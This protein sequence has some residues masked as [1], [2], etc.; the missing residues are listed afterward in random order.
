MVPPLIILLVYGVFN[1]YTRIKRPVI[2]FAG[3][4]VF[5]AWHGVYLWKYIAE[6]APWP[7]LI[8][9]ESRD[10]Y[11]S[12][13]LPEY[14]TFRFINRETTANARIYL[15]FVGRRAYYCQRNY[16]HDGADLPGF[17]LGAIR[18]A[19]NTEQLAQSFRQK[20][21]THLMIRE[22]LLSRFLN[23]NLTPNQARLW[24]EFTANRLR[25]SFR[26]SGHAVY[27]LNG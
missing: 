2:L 23:D 24:N 13:T 21:I 7:Y 6:A 3:L 15:L 10:D 22:D 8:G 14:P 11:L 1:I 26:E 19:K 12:R 4:F 17:L 5:A 27:Q 20:Q 18:S 9:A 25:L 16:F